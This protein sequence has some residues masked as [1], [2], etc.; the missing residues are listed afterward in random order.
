MINGKNRPES[1]PKTMD[2]P[3]YYHPGSI[4]EIPQ[5]QLQDLLERLDL[6]GPAGCRKNA[7][8]EN[9]CYPDIPRFS[10]RK[11]VFGP[12]DLQTEIRVPWRGM[13]IG[14]R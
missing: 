13:G 3:H 14:I 8:K 9:C 5:P 4:P 11:S 12:D 1:V 2:L 7:K 6:Y 10:G